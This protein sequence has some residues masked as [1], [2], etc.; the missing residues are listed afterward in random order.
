M[1]E[2]HT[3]EQDVHELDYRSGDGVEVALF[4]VVDTD[5]AVVVVHDERTS[6]TLELSVL[7]GECALDV[8]NHPYA[9]AA[10]RGVE[11][12]ADLREPVYA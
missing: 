2:Q 11:Y 9:Y 12:E 1:T 4:W 8:F 10:A 6:E 5:R 7:P 3:F